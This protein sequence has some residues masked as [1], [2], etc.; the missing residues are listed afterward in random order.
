M[1]ENKLKIGVQPMW[2]V[3]CLEWLRS[4]SKSGIVPGTVFTDNPDH[5]HYLTEEEWD[6]FFSDT[7]DIIIATNNVNFRNIKFHGFLLQ[8][9]PKY[10]EIYNNGDPAHLG[11]GYHDKDKFLFD[12]LFPKIKCKVYVKSINTKAG[13]TVNLDGYILDKVQGINVK[14]NN[15]AGS[16][17]DQ[18]LEESIVWAKKNFNLPVLASGGITNKNDIDNAFRYGADAVLIG[19]LFA[20][21]KE[22]NLS[23]ESKQM[24]ISKNSSDLKREQ[25]NNSNLLSIGTRLENDDKN[26]S[27]NL[28]HTV[29]EGKN[30]ILYA[31]KAIDNIHA[32]N[33][34]KTIVSELLQQ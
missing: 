28:M 1:L 27:K 29:K 6:D 12:V 23:K 32:E 15:A 19:T 13:N 24:L 16:T 3:G 17:S 20:V 21:A 18:T 2:G 31:G 4:L 10:V 7:R 22:S 34:I 11:I 14:N 5:N 33:D 8:Y 30:G 25:I 9:K 26:L